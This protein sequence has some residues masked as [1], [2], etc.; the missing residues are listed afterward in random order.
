M[1]ASAES[2]QSMWTWTL[3]IYAVVLIV[4]AA[5]LTLILLEAKKIHS[6]VSEIWN[7]GQKVA[8][9]TIHIS[10]LATTNHVAAQILASAK[11]VVGGTAALQGHAAGCPGC[12]ACVLGRRAAP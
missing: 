8:N 4:V 6:G 3:I 10:L 12:P 1:T 7:V 9:N 11:G 5:L 2:I